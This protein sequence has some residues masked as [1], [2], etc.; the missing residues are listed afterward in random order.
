MLSSSLKIDDSRTTNRSQL[1][2][3]GN[4]FGKLLFDVMDVSRKMRK[5]GCGNNTS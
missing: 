2:W 1:E 5:N 3:G 4:L